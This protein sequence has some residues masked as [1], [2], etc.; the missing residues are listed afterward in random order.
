M[1][2]CLVGLLSLLSGVAVWWVLPAVG[3]VAGGAA[4]DVEGSLFGVGALRGMRVSGGG[5]GGGDSGGGRVGSFGSS[6]SGDDHDAS[7]QKLLQSSLLSE[8]GGDFAF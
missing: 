7:F 3:H 6:V 8:Q 5:S 2:T 1:S 4:L